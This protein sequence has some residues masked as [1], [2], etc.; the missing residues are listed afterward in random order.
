MERDFK[1][2]EEPAAE[3]GRPGPSN[4]VVHPLLRLQA[5]AGNQ[6][7]M[8][9]I[10]SEGQAAEAQP[11]D[12]IALTDM[13][14]LL[15]GG[16]SR[17]DGGTFFS[18]DDEGPTSQIPAVSSPAK[19]DAAYE[20]TMGIDTA[21]AANKMKPV[22]GVDGKTFTAVG[23]AG[24]ADGKVAFTFDRAFVGDYDYAAAGKPVRGAHVSISA[25]VTNCGVHNDVKLVQ[26]WRAIKKDGDKMVTTEP[27]SAMRKKRSGW[28]DAAAPSRGW[29][30][31]ETDEGRSPFFVTGDLYGKHGTA[32][33]DANLRDSP[34]SWTDKRN[35]GKEFRTCAVS[36]AGGKGT[37]L[38]CVDWGYYTDAAGTVTMYPATPVARV[39]AV[40]EM[41]GAVSR[42]EALP[43]HTKVNLK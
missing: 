9:L 14:E 24:K 2:G 20:K 33:Q 39:G 34:G 18:A 4:S 36:Y 7:V 31:D 3:S 41:A 26:I 22:A 42:W 6:A 19:D 11:A 16:M 38:A 8:R 15:E 29:M 5:T 10:E 1:V 37:V 40:P 35:I 28:D 12:D 13:T 32:T 23:C 25:K 43:G 21:I 27:D 30:V 17:L